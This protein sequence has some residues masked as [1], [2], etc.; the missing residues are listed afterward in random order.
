MMPFHAWVDDEANTAS[1]EVCQTCLVEIKEDSFQCCRL[2]ACSK[3]R[4]VRKL[5]SS[6]SH[7]QQH[8]RSTVHCSTHHPSRK[9]PAVLTQSSCVRYTHTLMDQLGK[10]R[11]TSQTFPRSS[12]IHLTSL[13]RQPHLQQSLPITHIFCKIQTCLELFW[14]GREDKWVRI[15]IRQG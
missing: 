1:P 7:E 13:W 9:N 5:D 6:I 12:H 2:S 15:T 8:C 10:L 14:I 11:A 4:P 3:W